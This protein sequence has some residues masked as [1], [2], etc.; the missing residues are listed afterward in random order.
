[1]RRAHWYPLLLMLLFPSNSAALQLRWS[2]GSTDLDF[3]S[4]T[5]C[6]LTVQADGTETALP[7]EW[8][9][10]WVADSLALQFL[11]TDSL[12]ACLLDDAQVSRIDGPASAADSAANQITAYFCSDP[13]GATSA[14]QA[15][16]L[17]AGGRGRLKVIALDPSDPD[18]SQ[19]VESNEVTY[20]GGIEGEYAPVVLRATSEHQSLQLRVTLIGA[21]LNAANSMAVLAPDSSWI[22]PLNVISRSDDSVTGVAAVAAPLPFCE[23]MV[24]SESGA[25]SAAA[26]TAEEEPPAETPLS[27]QGQYFEGLLQPPLYTLPPEHGYTIQPKDFAFTRGFVDPSSNRTPSISSTSATTTGTTRRRLPCNTPSSTKRTSVT[28]GRWISTPGTAPPGSTSP[29]Q[30]RLLWWAEKASSMSFM[31]G[32]RTL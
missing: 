8:R 15:V 25:V 1:M 5:R 6:T 28:F 32:H 21:G 23:A 16:D 31:Y 13:S 14:M 2:N 18:S 7:S 29:T 20:N 17:P 9:L 24:G 19:I 11:A 26:L 10:L 12:Q 22:V 3:S 4:A 30:S 27:C